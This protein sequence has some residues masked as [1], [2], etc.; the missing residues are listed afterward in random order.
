MKSKFLTPSELETLEEH[1][2][3]TEWLPLR[4]ALETGLRVGDIVGL[5]VSDLKEDGIHYCAQKTKKRGVASISAALRKLLPQTGK[6]LFPSPYK[7]GKHLTRQAV[8]ARVKRAA[9]RARLDEKGISPHAMRKVFA[10]ELYREKGFEAVRKA[11]Q[12]SNAATTEIYSFADWSTGEEAEK[13]LLRRDLQ[14][15]VKMVLEA[16]G[17]D[18]KPKEKGQSAKKGVQ[19]MTATELNAKCKKS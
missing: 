6:W 5:R 2:N 3:S 12:H 1:S 15:I 7:R 13:P 4:V 9:E 8:W 18:S 10:V 17:T 16:L 11:L 19:K 14:L